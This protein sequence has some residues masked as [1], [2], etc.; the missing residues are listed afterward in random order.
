MHLTVCS[1]QTRADRDSVWAASVTD[2]EGLQ[3][4]GSKGVHALQDLQL[5]LQGL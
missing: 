4:A 5:H 2:L 1:L 3:L